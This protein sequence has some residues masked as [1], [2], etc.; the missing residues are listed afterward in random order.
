MVVSI[1][2][3]SRVTEVENYKT[4]ISYKDK[5]IRW[6]DSSDTAWISDLIEDQQ[7][8]AVTRLKN[9]LDENEMATN[10]SWVGMK[11]GKEIC[12]R[13]NMEVTIVLYVCFPWL[14]QTRTLKWSGYQMKVHY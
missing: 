7:D 3:L 8:K 5:E 4:K 6:S 12:E 2:M 11:I 1:L 10:L 14:K 9:F 13:I